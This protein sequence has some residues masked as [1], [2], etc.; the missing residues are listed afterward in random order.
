MS[1]TAY[2]KYLRVSPRRSR[3]VAKKIKGK[4]VEEALA[5]LRFTP[6]KAAQ[7]LYKAIKS[8]A[9]NAINRGEA[10]DYS[11][12]YIKRLMINEGPR[13]KRWRPEARGRVK[14]IRHRYSHY[15]VEVERIGG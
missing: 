9:D 7:L 5:I 3:A 2:I 8:A 4:N 6:K 12:L 15:F 10:S 14:I 13:L 11:Q 1:A